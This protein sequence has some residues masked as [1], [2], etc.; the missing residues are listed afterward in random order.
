MTAKLLIGSGVFAIIGSV[1]GIGWGIYSSFQHLKDSEA[2]GIGAVGS[3][4]KFALLSNI[5]FFVGLI[6]V[7]VGGLTL[8]RKKKVKSLTKISVD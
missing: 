1:L 6:L 5:F 2:A 7:V 3:S 8:Y 4:I